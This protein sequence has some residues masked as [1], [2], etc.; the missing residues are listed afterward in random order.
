MN[1][2]AKIAA[3]A[4]AA[5]AATPAIAAPVGVTGAP[6]SATA[7]I[8]KPLTLSATGA[9]DQPPENGDLGIEDARL[10]APGAP[11]RSVLLERISR[12]DAAQMPPLATLR[13]DDDAASLLAD[14][15]AS[16]AGCE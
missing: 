16:L 9:C 7:R 12:R 1:K 5:L 2:F 11:E 4:A 14:W 13:V 6:P 10:I 3:V 8:I 15:I